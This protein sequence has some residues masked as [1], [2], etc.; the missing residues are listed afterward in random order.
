MFEKISEFE[1]DTRE[2]SIYFRHIFHRG[3]MKNFQNF[4][5]LKGDNE[6][7]GFFTEREHNMTTAGVECKMESIEFYRY[8][9]KMNKKIILS[10]PKSKLNRLVTLCVHAYSK[11]R[12]RLMCE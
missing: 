1:N 2:R 3:F 7:K 9:R 5:I 12:V 4:S 11:C 6:E 10:P 8:F